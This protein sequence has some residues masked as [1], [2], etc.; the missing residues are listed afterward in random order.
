MVRSAVGVVMTCLPSRNTVARSHSSKTSSSRWLT[1]RTATPRARRLRTI[2]NR[3]STSWAES[4][5]VGSSRIEDARL[6]RQRLGDL[7]E[8]LV[9]HRQ[10]ADRRA[11]IDLDG[12]LLEQRLGRP[13]RGAPVE[14]AEPAGRRVPDEHVLGDGQV[15]EEARLLVDDGD[16]ERA[17]LRRTV[18]RDRLPVEEDRPAVG[19]MDAGEDLDQRAL[20][21]AVLADEGVDLARDE[22]ERD[23]VERLGRRESL[24][25]PAQLGAGRGGDGS[26][27]LRLGHRS[28][29]RRRRRRRAAVGAEQPDVD[30]AADQVLDHRLAAPD[31]R[32]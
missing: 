7:D 30:A 25:D 4:D 12:E 11:D 21:R 14:H 19:L 15:R 32:R 28:R 20:A 23:V 26:D 9:G 24:G 18:D 22:V 16:P 27:G 8:L 31:R 3:R 6:E 10:A 13:A 5:A 17:G 29:A 1:N 2:A